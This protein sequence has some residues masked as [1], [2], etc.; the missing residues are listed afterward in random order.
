MC[1]VSVASWNVVGLPAE[2]VSRIVALSSQEPV[3]DFSLKPFSKSITSNAND[4]TSHSD[5]NSNSD[6][7]ED[8]DDD[9]DFRQHV[10]VYHSDAESDDDS[11]VAVSSHLFT[12]LT[13]T[14]T[15]SNSTGNITSNDSSQKLLSEVRMMVNSIQ[16]KIGNRLFVIT[17]P[18]GSVDEIA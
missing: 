7:E 13:A 3:E 11:S 14:T 5:N 17:I 10:V 12:R 15:T 1:V 4:P 16:C 6:E 2:A 9:G 18:D 8:D